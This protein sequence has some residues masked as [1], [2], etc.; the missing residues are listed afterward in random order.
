MYFKLK[1]QILNV[2]CECT[3]LNTRL[4]HFF[5]WGEAGLEFL[6]TLLFIHSRGG[7]LVLVVGYLFSL[8]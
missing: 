6:V 2:P 5:H 4:F 3:A 7:G 1:L 8:G